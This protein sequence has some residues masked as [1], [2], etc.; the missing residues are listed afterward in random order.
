MNLFS[1]LVRPLCLC[2]ARKIGHHCGRHV[3]GKVLDVGAGRCLIAKELQEN[4]NAKVTCID[5]DD[6]NETGIPLIVYDGRKIPFSGNKFDTV[7]LVYVL[8]HCEDP[9]AVLEECKRVCKNNGKIIVFEDF[10]FIWF[11]YFMDIVA[12]RLHDVATPLNF[13][14]KKEWKRLFRSLGLEI[15]YSEDGVEKQFFYPFVEHTMLVLKV[16]K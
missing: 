4:Y 13:K 6:L 5:V 16:K 2:K 14:S 1:R 3:K 9:V 8:H 10:G 15:A 7:L 11:T 12:N